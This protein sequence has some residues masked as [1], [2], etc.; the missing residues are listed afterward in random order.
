VS[1]KVTICIAT[2][3]RP[4]GLRRLLEGI[5][6]Q[7]FASLPPPHVEIVVVDNHSAESARPVCE[8]A[9]SSLPFPLAYVVEERRGIPYARNRGLAEAAADTDFFA[10]V[11]DDEVPEPQWLEE[12][13]RVQRDHGAAAVTGP[14][15]PYFPTQPRPWVRHGSFF[16][17]PRHAT[18]ERLGLA[19]TGNALIAA[20]AVASTPQPFEERFALSGGSD[21]FFFARLND[22]GGRIIWADDAVVHEWVPESRQRVGWVLRRAYR[23]MIDYMQVELERDGTL[24]SR[25]GRAAHG[26]RLLTAAA[27][28]L[29]LAT[30]CAPRDR[31]VRLI[32]ALQLAARGA[33]AV[34]AAL[35]RRYDE[36]RNVHPV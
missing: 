8:A 27:L 15:L 24:R 30:A 16:D 1:V 14:V 5:A 12:L 36:Y 7:R 35:G 9:R 33:G 23:G 10:F 22:A 11:D 26:V 21:S 2:C 20:S 3:D 32:E 19:R 29:P 28:R 31:G 34:A 13:L 6:G 25:A 4:E 17:R 18:G